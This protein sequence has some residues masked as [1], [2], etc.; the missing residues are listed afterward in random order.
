LNFLKM[1]EIR[2]LN[3]NLEYTDKTEEITKD[4]DQVFKGQSIST[5]TFDDSRIYLSRV[6]INFKKNRDEVYLPWL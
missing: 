6:N 4:V 3:H 1:E 2:N 5:V